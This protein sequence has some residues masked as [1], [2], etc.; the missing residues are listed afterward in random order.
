MRMPGYPFLLAAI[1]WLLGPGEERVM[2]VQA[3]IDVLTCLGIASLAAK[4][5]SRAATIALWMAMLCPFTANY[6]ATP[7]TET[8]A[9]A[10]TTACLLI[11]CV[12]LDAATLIDRRARWFIAGIVA[13]LATL[14]RPESPLV[15]AAGGLALAWG[16][17]RIKGASAGWRRREILGRAF[18]PLVRTA[19]LMAA[20]L[21]LVLLPWGI[22]SEE[23]RVGEEGRS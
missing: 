22:R 10:L 8:L 15:L 21:L 12:P 14:V 13:G 18:L 23:R 5:N 3:G 19:V 1:E 7:L 17:L 20:G 9:I 2:V 6:T 11:M 4:I 16:C